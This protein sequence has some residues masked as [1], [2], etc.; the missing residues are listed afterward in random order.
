[1][2]LLVIVVV[3]YMIYHNRN[4]VSYNYEASIRN[5]RQVGAQAVSWF[6]NHLILSRYLSW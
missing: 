5:E 4:K 1:M 2:V 3:T 6:D